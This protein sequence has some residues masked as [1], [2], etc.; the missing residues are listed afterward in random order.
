MGVKIKGPEISIWY[1]GKNIITIH[2]YDDNESMVSTYD[3]NKVTV[4]SED[5]FNKTIDDAFD[6]LR[7]LFKK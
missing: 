3:F 1:S 4:I 6:R 2:Y 5:E 7:K